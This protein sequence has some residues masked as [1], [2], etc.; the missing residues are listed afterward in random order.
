MRWNWWR[1]SEIKCRKKVSIF[2]IL[3]LESNR[4]SSHLYLLND[5]LL[6]QRSNG[7]RI[8]EHYSLQIGIHTYLRH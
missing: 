6:E 5:V 3:L 2:D 7:S 4:I 8:K 1:P